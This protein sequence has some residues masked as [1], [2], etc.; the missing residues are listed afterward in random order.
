MGERLKKE[1]VLTRNYSGNV[2]TKDFCSFAKPNDY[3][4]VTT[5]TNQDGYDINIQHEGSKYPN[6]IKL[7]NGEFKAIKAIIK[8]LNKIP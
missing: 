5:W 2:A 7:T 4:E 1:V 8:Q 3:I 6:L